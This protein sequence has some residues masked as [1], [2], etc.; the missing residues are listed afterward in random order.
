MPAKRTKPRPTLQEALPQELKKHV[1]A[2]HVKGGL[3]LLQR[4]ASNVLVLNC[5]HDLPDRSIIEHTISLVDLATAIGFNS[6]NHRVL[7]ETLEALVDL[8]LVWNVLDPD[9]QR[10]WGAG[11]F[12]AAVRI[13]DGSGICR[14]QFPQALRELLYN[15]QI[16]ARVN[17]LVQT[18]FTSAAGLALYENCLRFRNTG[19]TG[20]ISV[21]DWRGLLGVEDDEYPEYK[22][23]RSKVIGPAIDQI[24]ECSDIRVAVEDKREKRRVVA[25]RFTITE[26]PAAEAAEFLA[27]APQ[28]LPPAL[29]VAADLPEDD[30]EMGS[31]ESDA[32]AFPRKRLVEFGLTGPQVE[33]ALALASADGAERVERNLAYVEAELAR[34]K[35]IEALG[36]YTH[37]AL[38][39]D[40]AG[41]AAAAERKRKA[42]PK[43]PAPAVAQV[44]L[45]LSPAQTAQADRDARE[46]AEARRLD[47]LAAALT[48][49][50]R[51]ALDAEATGLL[52]DQTYAG[53]REIE[54]AVQN[55]TEASLGPA[56]R[57]ALT[58]ARR[59]V[60]AGRL[61][62]TASAAPADSES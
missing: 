62:G 5:Y 43:R 25:L 56:N 50:D 27:Q 55:G 19:S 58:T 37:R 60:I 4:K 38:Q 30:P 51:V 46:S 22:K 61:P 36:A 24:N 59:D 3:S 29:L 48:G 45:A 34:G 41:S 23:F 49:P 14:Y 11:A 28:L 6:N 35:E 31:P 53:W 16:Y 20:W 40:W 13:K 52:R 2:I 42:T 7:K 54:E 12:L 33:A 47:A 18:R 44:E 17:L 9:G 32:G 57:G 26:A 1:G 10:E 39:G 15:P 21:D 8:K